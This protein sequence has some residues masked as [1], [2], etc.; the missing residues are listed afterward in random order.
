MQFLSLNSRYK[1]S[2]KRL[3]KMD[4]SDP[5]ANAIRLRDDSSLGLPFAPLMHSSEACERSEAGAQDASVSL[6]YSLS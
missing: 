3:S 2:G 4:L 5:R 1:I 6:W